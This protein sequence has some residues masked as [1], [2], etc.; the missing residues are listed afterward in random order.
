MNQVGS[1]IQQW[2]QAGEQVDTATGHRLFVR[3][4][5][6]LVAAPERTLLLLH[7]F[8]ESSFSFHRVWQGLAEGFDRVVALDFL[9]F[10]CSDKPHPYPYSLFEQADLALEVWSRLGLGGGH[11]LA[12]DMGDTVATELLTRQQ[13][14]LL[15]A[16]WRGLQS[17]TFTNGG[18]LIERARLRLGQ[19]LL[20]RPRLGPAL[21]PLMGYPVFR[22][23]VRSAS[24]GQGPGEE[25]LRAMWNLL[26]CGYGRRTVPSTLR[27]IHQ[28][29]RYQ[30]TR[31]LP[32]LAASGIP[33]HFCWGD[34]DRVA[35]VAI[36][37]TLVHQ[38]CPDA[39]LTRLRGVG[40][41][42]QLEA[43]DRWLEASRAFWSTL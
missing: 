10:G 25:D 42:C 11:L 38:H 1:P 28:R 21:I 24:G 6:A 39:R 9:G 30:N 17:L 40:H 26:H 14:G 33:I 8:P 12:H 37:E 34:A 19:R 43:P 2:Q 18:M 27:Y 5:G 4:A 41:F 31:W 16:G 20:S 32:A 36:A 35:P 7:G 23:Q 3:S 13:R 29:R 15:P 22:R